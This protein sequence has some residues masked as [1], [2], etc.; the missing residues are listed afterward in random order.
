MKIDPI[1]KKLETFDI[2]P[3]FQFIEF[4]KIVF[5]IQMIFKVVRGG[6]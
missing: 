3:S 2:W 4:L 5:Q 1:F 6:V